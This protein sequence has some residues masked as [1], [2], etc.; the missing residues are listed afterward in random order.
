MIEKMRN[1]NLKLKGVHVEILRV[2]ITAS[3][4]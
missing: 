2:L 3:Q 4:N 1:D